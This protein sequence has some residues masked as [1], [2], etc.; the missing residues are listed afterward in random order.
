MKVKSGIESNSDSKVTS[1]RIE[2]PQVSISR[3][4]YR[5]VLSKSLTE[6]KE[7]VSLY[8]PKNLSVIYSADE[9][10][11]SQVLL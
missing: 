6:A 11:L 4:P 9:N 5:E 10:Q 1:H 7:L 3:V 8:T 2:G